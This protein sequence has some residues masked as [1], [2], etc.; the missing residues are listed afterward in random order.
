M[1]GAAPL[2]LPCKAELPTD[3]CGL[4]FE[5]ARV[6]DVNQLGTGLEQLPAILLVSPAIHASGTFL[7]DLLIETLG[8]LALGA[9]V[10]EMLMSRPTGSFPQPPGRR[11]SR[12]L[13]ANDII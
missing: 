9:N 8:I 1:R 7:Y 13:T 10:P 3:E 5:P 4:C 11:L 2:S 12:K 6:I